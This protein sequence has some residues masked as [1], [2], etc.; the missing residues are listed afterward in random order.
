LKFLLKKLF[1]KNR[2][3]LRERKDLA[4]FDIG[5]WSYG[6]LTVLR[7]RK[8]GNLRIG[9]YCSF[10]ANT[11]VMLGGDHST[12]NISTF[13]F[14]V[15]MGGVP[16][17]AH[18]ATRGDVEIGNDVWVARDAMILSGVKIGTGAVIGAASLVTK[19]VPP[20]AVVAGNPARIVRLR[21]SDEQIARLLRLEWWNWEDGAVKAHAP[22]LLSNDIEEFL[23]VAEG[24]N[25]QKE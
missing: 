12:R 23:S 24:S 4:G 8:N 16:D 17:D 14:G 25:R 3:F 10:A 6:G 1:R 15:L 2:T 9:K 19:D 13:P 21:F 22:L 5:E 18:A 11:V 20:Y 7:W